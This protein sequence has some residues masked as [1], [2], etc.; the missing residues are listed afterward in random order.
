MQSFV[1]LPPAETALVDNLLP[2]LGH[3]CLDCLIFVSR[4]PRC[5]KFVF[6]LGE[7]G[8]RQA[9]LVRWS[10]LLEDYLVRWLLRSNRHCLEFNREVS[11][12]LSC[13][14]SSPL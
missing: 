3:H 8:L 4:G 7:E 14:D 12:H 11:S 10:V 6:D 13:A 9:A 5:Y 2:Q 1:D